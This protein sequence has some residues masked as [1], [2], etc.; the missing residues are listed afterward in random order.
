VNTRLIRALL[1]I[2][3]GVVLTPVA[4][5][6]GL[7]DILPGGGPTVAHLPESAMLMLLGIG[8]LV[9][10]NSV[11]RQPRP[12]PTARVTADVQR[13][14]TTLALTTTLNPAKAGAK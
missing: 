3:G 6:V 7:H 13:P 9:I 2:V 5:A 4:Y 12:R 10:A 8:L 1:V 14:R 11:R